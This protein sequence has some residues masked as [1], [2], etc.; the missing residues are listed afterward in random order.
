MTNPY[1]RPDQPG[2]PGWGSGQD[3]TIPLVPESGYADRSSPWSEGYEPTAVEPLGAPGPSNYT[4]PSVPAAPA[5]AATG[6]GLPP[7]AAPYQPQPVYEQPPVGYSPYGLPQ[8]A[9]AQLVPTGYPPSPYPM[10]TGQ[11][12]EHPNAVPTLVLAL[13]G[14]MFGLTFPIAW[15]LGAKGNNDVRRNPGRWRPSSVM[16]AGMVI[17]IIGTVFMLLGVA[18]FVL[19]MMA[20][21][22]AA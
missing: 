16:T 14:F 19:F 9:H 10:A 5:Q 3:P 4:N 2:T 11:L 7:M 1:A 18:A 20:L 21:V 15:Y 22:V 13:L 17:G 12:P 6:Q 8:T